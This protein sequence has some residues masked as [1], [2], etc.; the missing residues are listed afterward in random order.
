[1][2]AR[3]QGT[4]TTRSNVWGLQGRVRVGAFGAACESGGSDGSCGS[5]VSGGGVAE[6]VTELAN[7][8]RGLDEVEQTSAPQ[9]RSLGAVLMVVEVAGGVLSTVS[10][11]VPVVQKL[12]K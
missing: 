2:F 3:L 10:T 4:R 6:D 11:A 1:M 8:L 5:S 12:V 7:Q 9:E